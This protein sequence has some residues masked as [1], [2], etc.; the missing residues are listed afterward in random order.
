MS[1]IVSAASRLSLS[2]AADAGPV[3]AFEAAAAV[4]ALAADPSPAVF[5]RVCVGKI[6]L[7]HFTSRRAHADTGSATRVAIC[8]QCAVV[9]TLRAGQPAT[10]SH[11]ALPEAT[12][13]ARSH[14]G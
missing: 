12:L 5:C 1:P 13:G 14:Y 11:A 6:A 10:S 2:T 4:N 9:A 7:L 8:P 3:S